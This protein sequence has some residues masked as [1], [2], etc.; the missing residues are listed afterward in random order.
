MVK[1]DIARPMFHRWDQ[2][3]TIARAVHVVDMGPGGRKGPHEGLQKLLLTLYL[4]SVQTAFLLA[5]IVY[6]GGPQGHQ[7]Y[8]L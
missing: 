6:F 8:N 3:V 7:S 1:C 5:D 4:R 2:G